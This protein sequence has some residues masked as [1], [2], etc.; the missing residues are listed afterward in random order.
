M[1]VTVPVVLMGFLAGCATTHAP[2]VSAP[3]PDEV[4]WTAPHVE[5]IT[6]P[7]VAPRPERKASAFEQVFPFEEGASYTVKVPVNYPVSV[8]LE[9][10]EQVDQIIY[11][12]RAALAE[13]EKESPWD[14]REGRSHD[15]PRPHVMIN[16]TKPGLSQGI[17]VTT[18]RRVYILDVRSVASGKVRVVR[19]DYGP[20]AVPAQAKPRLL[21]DPSLP[22][23]YYGGYTIAPVKGNPPSWTPRQ[24][25]H[26]QEGKT[27]ILFPAYLTTITAPL[28]RLVG[29]SGPELV[30]YRQVGTTYVLDELFNLAELRVG[31]GKTAEVVRIHRG[32]PQRLACPG[33]EGCPVWPD[34]LAG[35]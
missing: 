32:P 22:Q 20:D 29:S 21:P 27:Y 30:N 15:T 24:V 14:V 10:G 26:D 9:A 34:R 28:L 17:L 2:V 6:P 13:G 25:V 11:G 19:W 8:M 1:R 33:A 7:P 3:I 12:D 18:N 31:G 16:V 4:G 23:V 35:R 5:P